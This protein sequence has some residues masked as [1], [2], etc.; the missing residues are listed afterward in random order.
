[1]DF[2][3]LAGMVAVF[4]AIV[5]LIVPR[6]MGFFFWRHYKREG[7]TELAAR[8]WSIMTGSVLRCMIEEMEIEKN[9]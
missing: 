9:A 4:C 1:M 8:A 5:I 2:L 6:V 7:N 3:S